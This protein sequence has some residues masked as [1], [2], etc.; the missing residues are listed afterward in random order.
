MLQ[1]GTLELAAAGKNLGDARRAAKRPHQVFASDDFLVEQKFKVVDRIKRHGRGCV[2]FFVVSDDECQQFDFLGFRCALRWIGVCQ[3][4]NPVHGGFVFLFVVDEADFHG[5]PLVE[6][7][8][9]VFGVCA[10]PFDDNQSIEVD[11]LDNNPVVIAFDIEDDTVASQKIC[12]TECVLDVLWCT[13]CSFK[14]FI[15][16]SGYGFFRCRVAGGEF[17]QQVCIDDLHCGAASSTKAIIF[18]ER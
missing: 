1:R 7:F 8:P 11:H 17:V 16:P 13:P 9:A 15:A 14:H 10:H 2:L 3:R 18:P 4:Q 5:Y 12:A 6:F